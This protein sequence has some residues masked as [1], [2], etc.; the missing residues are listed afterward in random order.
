MLDPHTHPS[1]QRRKDARPAELTA[2]ALALFVERGY[3][4][5]RLEDVAARAGVSKG[6]LYLYFGN[7]EELFKAVIREGIV[8]V[9]EIGEALLDTFRDDPERLLRE[10]VFGWWKMIGSTPLG[11]IPKL[12]IAEAA[13]FPEI[14]QFHF[15][16]VIVRIRRLLATALELGAA[17]G[18]F[19]QVDVEA[20][21][22]IILAPLL[23]LAIW[24]HSF[25]CCAG[26]GIDPQ[27]YLEA[28]LDLILNGLRQA[29]AQGGTK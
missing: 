12:M 18:V 4:A 6:T 16:E 5:T 17:K 28:A 13:N 19:R 26:A 8:P 14:A 20:Q 29:P 11:G 15:D 21:V 27:R 23:M 10:I 9:I 2:A 25:A 22:Q 24:G 3:A 1:H 7:K